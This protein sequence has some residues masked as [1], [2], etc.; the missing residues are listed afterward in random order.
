MEFKITAI[1]QGSG[2]TFWCG[3]CKKS[4]WEAWI[5]KQVALAN[6][7]LHGINDHHHENYKVG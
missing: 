6:G 1:K 4:G 3:S 2:Y 7:A 5:S